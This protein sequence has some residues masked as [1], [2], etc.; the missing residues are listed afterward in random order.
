MHKEKIILLIKTVKI[1]N[2][3]KKDLKQ[4]KEIVAKE[5]GE[6]ETRIREVW[7]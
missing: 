7:I 1:L 2:M 5:T 4:I 6:S 3:N